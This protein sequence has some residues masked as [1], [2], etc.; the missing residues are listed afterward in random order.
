MLDLP[1]NRSNTALE[2]T[3]L[4]TRKLAARAVFSWQRSH[5]GLRSTEF[6]TDE[7]L[8]QFDR[9]VRDNN[10]H[11][12]GA[13]AYSFSKMDVFVSYVHYVSGTDT[14]AGRVITTGM[15]WPFELQ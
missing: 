11:M 6:D 9:L 12:G 14:H 2:S 4:V 8:Q 1:N 5:G 15:S 7:R 13:V 10:F 3:F